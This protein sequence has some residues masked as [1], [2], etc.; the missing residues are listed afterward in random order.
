[1]KA[2][3]D[4]SAGDLDAAEQVCAE[5]HVG[6]EDADVTPPPSPTSS[7]VRKGKRH[8]EDELLETLQKEVQESGDIIKSL[9]T[10]Q[11]VTEEHAFA[12][13]VRDSLLS[14]PKEMFCKA[15]LSISKI[16]TECW[17]RRTPP[18]NPPAYRAPP[19]RPRLALQPSASCSEQY[20]PHPSMWRHQQP[21]GVSV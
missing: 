5:H 11:P 4:A 8:A 18:S 13:F 1:M 6:E 12:N 7:T 20:Q 14:M 10:Q 21:Q 3:I 9:N 19:V 15:R 2:A 17:T 16:I